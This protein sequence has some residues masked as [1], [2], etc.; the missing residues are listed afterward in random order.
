MVLLAQLKLINRNAF[1]L[2]VGAGSSSSNK[3]S[4]IWPNNRNAVMKLKWMT[5]K[6]WFALW[7]NIFHFVN[8]IMTLNL[9]NKQAA[10][11]ENEMMA[12][13]S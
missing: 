12:N 10:Y 13:E 6:N 2:I 3:G 4:R 5:M 9:V 8:S 7:K 11:L 1:S